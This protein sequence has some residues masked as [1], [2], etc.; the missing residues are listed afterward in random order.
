MLAVQ[1]NKHY[2]QPRYPNGFDAGAPGDYYTQG[3]A[4]GAIE[5]AEAIL[6]FCRN[7]IR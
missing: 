7:Q 1:E 6:A 4:D 3:E 2:I 5:H